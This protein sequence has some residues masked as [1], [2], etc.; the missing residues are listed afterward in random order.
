M[1]QVIAVH[2]GVT[3]EAGAS[4]GSSWEPAENAKCEWRPWEGKGTVTLHGGAS[5]SSKEHCTADRTQ[6][7]RNVSAGHADDN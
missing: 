5:R 1:V 4:D 3:K 2:G 7:G 6:E